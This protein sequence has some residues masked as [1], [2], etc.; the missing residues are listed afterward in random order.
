MSQDRT[1]TTDG[2]PLPNFRGAAKLYRLNPPL[3][4]TDYVCDGDTCKDVEIPTEY[5]I[6]SAATVLGDPETYI[7]PATVLGEIE[8]WSEMR[9]S[10]KGTLSHDDVLAACGYS[11]DRHHHRTHHPR[12]R[13]SG[14]R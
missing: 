14:R 4:R 7:F 13:R 1:A 8:S 12:G 11:H 5:V 3:I 9:G 10:Q 6:V 2:K